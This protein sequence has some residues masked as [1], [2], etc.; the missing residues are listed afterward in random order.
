[1]ALQALSM[2]AERVYGGGLDVALTIMTEAS[3]TQ[4]FN[5][6]RDN[7]LQLQQHDIGYPLSPLVINA[8][9]NGCFMLQVWTFW[10][11]I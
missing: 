2:F 8:K 1:M 10:M 3:D 9:G 7:S 6:S 5:I 4:D 11:Q